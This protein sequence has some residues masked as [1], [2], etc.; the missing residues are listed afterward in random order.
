MKRRI[1]SWMLLLCM[2]AA[3]F[4]SCSGNEK[5]EKKEMERGSTETGSGGNEAKPVKYADGYELV[6]HEI[7]LG[8][9]EQMIDI[10][11][12]ED[13]GFLLVTGRLGLKSK[14]VHLDEELKPDQGG[15]RTPTTP[16]RLIAYQKTGAD[17]YAVVQD[18]LTEFSGT[19]F[20]IKN[21]ETVAKGRG[22]P[23]DT[24]T[25]AF[26]SLDGT[27]VLL[28]RDGYMTILHRRK[29]VSV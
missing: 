18:S 25:Y 26:A 4:G 9:R 1:V 7:P 14:F 28:R 8:S 20:V 29:G 13:G 23:G 24:T 11:P 17:E 6:Y 22:K 10:T 27:P 12:D 16:E 15:E 21:G 5:G 2:I 19:Y 3:L